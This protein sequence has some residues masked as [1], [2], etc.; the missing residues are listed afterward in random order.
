MLLYTQIDL[1]V[2]TP[3]E[4]KL[5]E[6]VQKNLMSKTHDIKKGAICIVGTM[7]K[8]DDWRVGATSDGSPIFDDETK[9]EW[10][11]FMENMVRAASSYDTYLE[12][13]PFQ[14][15][16]EFVEW[17][18]ELKEAAEKLP[19]YRIVVAF[20]LF[21]DPYGEMLHND[22]DHF[23]NPPRPYQPPEPSR[24]N[25]ALNHFDTPEVYI[26]LPNGERSYCRITKEYPVFVFDDKRFQHAGENVPDGSVR[27]QLIVR[28]EL[29]HDKHKELIE[30]SL[31]K[32]P[33]NC[34]YY[35]D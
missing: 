3:P 11:L 26:N 33:E 35:P 28:G 14:W 22:N 13:L 29:D 19:F 24:Y 5:F 27:V 8:L 15:N 31:K 25:I 16:P 20:L 34:S 17:F 18:P 4:E 1:P 21:S 6:F 9:D 23:K 2:V 12:N 30:R 32:F 7:G 10:P